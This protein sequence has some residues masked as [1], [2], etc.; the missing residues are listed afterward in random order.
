VMFEC[1]TTLPANNM[2]CD[3]AQAAGANRLPVVVGSGLVRDASSTPTSGRVLKIGLRPRWHKVP[4]RHL[5]AAFH[6]MS[7][8]PSCRAQRLRSPD[9]GALLGQPGFR[10]SEASI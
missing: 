7:V 1:L 10:I 8:L 5:L 4:H 3:E 6:A 2:A 9:E